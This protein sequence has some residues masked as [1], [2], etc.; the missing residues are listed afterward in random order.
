MVRYAVSERIN[1]APEAIFPMLEDPARWQWM[2]DGSYERLPGGSGQVGTRYRASMQREGLDIDL[3]MEVVDHQPGRRIA[4][5]T[6][7]GK[8][9][10]WDG[11]F[12][13]EP[14]GQGSVVRSEGNIRLFGL[15]RLLEPMMTGE[16]RK[17]EQGELARLK[18]M[19][20]AAAG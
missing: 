1:R 3:L 14:E 17:E 15:R 6:I 16:V 18:T 12:A 7:S 20:E 9:M 5:R 2:G 4:F 13:V 10:R 19:V 11:S 8:G